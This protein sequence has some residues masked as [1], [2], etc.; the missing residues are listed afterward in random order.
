MRRIRDF[1]NA[2]AA[3][4][5]R[6]TRPEEAAIC[7]SQVALRT[8]NYD[9]CARIQPQCLSSSRESCGLDVLAKRIQS[10]AVDEA[11]CKSLKEPLP[12]PDARDV[13]FQSVAMRLKQPALCHQLRND[14][15]K[16]SCLTS[17][18]PEVDDES[19]CTAL[20]AYPKAL[21]ASEADCWL[22]LAEKKPDLRLCDKIAFSP[23]TWAD[24]FGHW[25]NCVVQVAKS[26]S[27]PDLCTHLKTRSRPQNY[28]ENAFGEPGCRRRVS[29]PS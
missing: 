2:V 5:E 21:G 1:G 4:C 20:A 12:K 8:L 23:N 19:A 3:D 6:Q 17:V 28:P 18:L 15:S 11:F 7:F 26:R 29:G 25:Y 27:Q 16:H 9:L 22:R 13:C 14:Q 24:N 10:G